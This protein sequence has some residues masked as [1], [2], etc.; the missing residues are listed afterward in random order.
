MLRDVISNDWFTIFLVLGL[1]L[2]TVS[3]FLFAHRFKD[4]LVV[5][6][7]SKYLKIYA[8]EQKFID[9][10]DALLFFNGI[11]S[12]SIFA[13]LSYSVLVNSSEFNINQF[14]KLLF[15]IGVLFLMKVLLERLIASLFNIDEVVDSYL[16]QKTTFKNYSGFILLPIN[17]LLIYALEPTKNLIYVIIG[18]IILI[19]IVGFATSFKNNQKL[20]INNIFYFILYLC[21]LEI[22]PYL[23]LYKLIKDFNA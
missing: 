5:I 20:L 21:A 13:F 22:G 4:F 23:I 7:N 16:F 1:G 3:K 10:F 17:C 6:G 12:V 15:G 8:R 19:N 2:I 14:F 9:G 11:L 18:L